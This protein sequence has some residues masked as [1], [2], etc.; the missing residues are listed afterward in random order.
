M[1]TFA[2]RSLGN[3]A[4]LIEFLHLAFV[5]ATFLFF[6]LPGNLLIALH[7]KYFGGGPQFEKIYIATYLI[8]LV[9][10]LLILLDLR[11]RYAVISVCTRES[12]LIAFM[13]SVFAVA[14]YAI[15]AKHSSI[16]PFADTFFA[17]LIVSIGY[18]C[19]PQ[20][21]L[22][23]SR[24]LLDIYFIVSIA[25][26]FYDYKTKSTIV[27]SIA[28]GSYD[29]YRATAFFEGPLAAALLLGFYSLVVLI[30]T[31]IRL[32]LRCAARLGLALL[33]FI[34]LLTTGGRASFVACALLAVSYLAI[35]LLI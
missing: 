12:T 13:I 22:S 25:I 16:A 7:W 18:V 8:I 27:P 4:W 34:A 28:G 21:Y 3:S 2:E 23:I 1:R 9:F 35:S 17:A 26:M 14:L 5:L 30:T 11:F 20:R 15:V 19:L 29:R 24:L 33:S 6:L 10:G 31:P 32:N